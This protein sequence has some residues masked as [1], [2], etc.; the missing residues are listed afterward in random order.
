MDCH[1][2]YLRHS[3]YFYSNY[4]V[5]SVFKDDMVGKVCLIVLVFIICVELS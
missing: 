4:I 2:N 3:K 1:S 5:H